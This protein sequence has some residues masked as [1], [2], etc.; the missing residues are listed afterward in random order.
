MDILFSI[1]IP[2]L[3]EEKYIGRT[4]QS[5]VSQKHQGQKQ[6][7]ISDNGSTDKTID[8]AKEFGIYCYRC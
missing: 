6:I 7:I 1:I 4:L 2:T 3:N 5:I 8:I